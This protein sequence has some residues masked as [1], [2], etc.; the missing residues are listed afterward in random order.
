[1]YLQTHKNAAVEADSEGKFHPIDSR[2][3]VFPCLSQNHKNVFW[4]RG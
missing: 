4:F 2:L 1:M 3:A